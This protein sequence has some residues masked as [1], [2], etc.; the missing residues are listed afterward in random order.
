MH[1]LFN[2]E[3]FENQGYTIVIPVC[4]SLLRFIFPLQTNIQ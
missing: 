2:N 3:V 1:I 4:H